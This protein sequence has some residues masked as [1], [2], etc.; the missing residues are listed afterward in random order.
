M[1]TYIKQMLYFKH[2]SFRLAFNYSGMKDYRWWVLVALIFLAGF[3]SASAQLSAIDSLKSLLS[4]EGTDTGKVG[5]FI[6][7]TNIYNDERSPLGVVY[8]DSAVT[9]AMKSKHPGRLARAFGIRGAAFLFQGKMEEAIR[10]FKQSRFI[11]GRTDDQQQLLY[12][13][14]SIATWYAYLDDYPNALTHFQHCL[15]ILEHVHDKK[16]EM[17]VLQ[18]MGSL[19]AL[20]GDTVR[21]IAF[22]NK[23][24]EAAKLNHTPASVG[25]L[26][27][28]SQ[29]YGLKKRMPEAIGLAQEIIRIG[30]A[31][32]S[33]YDESCGIYAVAA[34]YHEGKN[35]PEALA[36]YGK[37][38]KL[39]QALEDTDGTLSGLI[40]L[41]GLYEAMKNYPLSI[42]YS[43][44][45]LAM[46]EKA[47]NLDLQAKA[48][49]Q[50]ADCYRFT[51]KYQLA[52]KA[53]RRF[54]ALNDSLTGPVNQ[55]EMGRKEA[56]FEQSKKLI[57][58]SLAQLEA[59]NQMAVKLKQQQQMFYAIGAFIIFLMILGI[60]FYR[61]RQI[62][63]QANIKLSFNKKVAEVEMQALRAQMNPHF[64]FNCLNSINRY[65]VKSDHMTASGYLTKFAKLIRLILDNAAQ[66]TT[67][68][69]NEL[70]LLQLYIEI[71][72]LRFNNRFAWVIEV[73]EG[74]DKETVFV[75]SM[76][77]Q[78]YVENAI[79]HG[80][81]HK[82]EKGLLTI[83]IG[84]SSNSLLEIIVEDD[85]VGRKL[86]AESSNRDAL[87]TRS[88]GMQI[89]K[90]RLHIVNQL[91]NTQARVRVEDLYAADG[92]AAGTRVTLNLPCE[93]LTST[94]FANN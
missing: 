81:M 9:W 64:I 41:G 94:S 82:D 90:D 89:T 80:L 3:Y 74:I 32:G 63:K 11:A 86:S 93:Q 57:A 10:D 71:E 16:M 26:L 24:I 13:S 75:P 91:F 30:R 36:Y 31:R 42:E 35:Y 55:K 70:Q 8:A 22:L 17:V 46:A 87:K 58:D 18:N 73:D 40:A 69:E 6:A 78:P 15:Q 56:Q 21:A 34:A 44:K 28:L 49:V 29:L 25:A 61:I 38:L 27:C 45:A 48:L 23:G 1:L 37:Y 2:V 12:V 39:T 68:L 59:R 88:Y 66:Q 43:R 19:Y 79:W 60:L 65:I 20:A 67:P 92:S 83:R 50:L 33:L 85:G 84:K 54:I 4:K 5:L 72:A 14:N 76:V 47:R 51:G 62:R 53:Y 7:I 52:D 77:I